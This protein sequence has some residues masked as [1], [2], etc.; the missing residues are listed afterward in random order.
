MTKTVQM[1]TSAGTLRIELD[2][3]AA[4]L[5]TANFLQ[6][7]AKG[8][9][10]G[11]VFHRVIKGF[12]LQGGGFEPGMKQKPTR[13]ADQERGQQRPEEQALHAG[14]GAHQRPA[15]GHGAVLHQHRRQRLPRLP[16]RKRAGL[17]L[18]RVRPRGAGHGRRRQPSRRC[19]PAARASTTTCRWKTCASS[20]LRPRRALIA[21]PWCKRP[22]AST[23]L[24]A[25]PQLRVCCAA[26]VARGGLHLRPAP[27]RGHATHLRRLRAHLR[28]TPPTPCSSWATC[29][30]SGWATTPAR[31]PLSAAA[32]TCWPKRPASRH[33][34][35]MAGNRDFLLGAAML[36][37]CGMMGLPD[38][39]VLVRLGAAGAAQPRRR[40][41]LGD[42]PT[43][44]SGRKCAARPGSSSSWPSRCPSGCRLP[45]RSAAPARAPAL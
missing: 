4:P 41:C 27:V 20:A 33:L 11:T 14:H 18:R 29:S 5:S 23:L 25:F 36:R 38:P 3:V 32:W 31:R 45:P 15:L 34:A 2:D 19:A 13:R 9:Y 40:L 35:F 44:P 1:D 26:G 17:G 7:V 30:R 10:D 8:H 21:R 28:H 37:D 6:Y 16:R 43:R 39:T 24:P 12:M 42:R 22:M